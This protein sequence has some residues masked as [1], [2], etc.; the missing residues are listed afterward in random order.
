MAK[1]GLLI[2]TCCLLVT[3]ANSQQFYGGVI[4]TDAK[5]YSYFKNVIDDLKQQLSAG[6]GSSFIVDSKDSSWQ[7]GIQI[8]YLDYASDSAYDKRLNIEN[9]DAALITSDGVHYLRIA[10]FTRQ[11]ISNGIYTYLDTLGFKWYHPG[12]TWCYVPHLKD[13]RIKLDEVLKPDFALWYFFR[14][15]GHSPQ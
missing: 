15:M 4:K 7:T 14:H 8:V 5:S 10:A 2:A 9:D 1:Y 12:N 13:I 3:T 11:G 6:T